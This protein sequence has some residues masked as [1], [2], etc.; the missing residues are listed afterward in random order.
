MKAYL[1]FFVLFQGVLLW[2]INILKNS[3]QK[4]A[5]CNDGT[6]PVY[7]TDFVSNS[8]SWLLYLPGGAMCPTP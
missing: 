7:L 6:A 2:K 1:L 8:T 3:L 4:N 5:I